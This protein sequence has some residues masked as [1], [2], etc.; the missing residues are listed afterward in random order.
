MTLHF[1]KLNKLLGEASARWDL[2][3]AFFSRAWQLRKGLQNDK[4][5]EPFTTVGWTDAFFFKLFFS[6][7]FQKRLFEKIDSYVIMFVAIVFEFVHTTVFSG[8]GVQ[9]VDKLL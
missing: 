2:R 9:T 8:Q 3:V 7:F 1:Q 6:F 4:S 5:S